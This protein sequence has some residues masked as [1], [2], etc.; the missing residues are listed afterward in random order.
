V[1]K[2]KKKIERWK[3]REGRENKRGRNRKMSRKKNRA[4][5]PCLAFSD[6]S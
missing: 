3:A 5:E 1:A 4:E 6:R 2:R